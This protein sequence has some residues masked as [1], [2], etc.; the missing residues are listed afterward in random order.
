[1]ILH[2]NCFF[3][4]F[5]GVDGHGFR[6]KFLD[7]FQDSG[8]KGKP[9]AM[10]GRRYGVAITWDPVDFSKPVDLDLQAL[11]VDKRGYIDAQIR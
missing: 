2:W 10:T 1:M 4:F 3:F 5:G 8:F 6:D 9:I 7:L 11:I